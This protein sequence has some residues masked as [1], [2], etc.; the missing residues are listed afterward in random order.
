MACLFSLA[1]LTCYR[2]LVA[3]ATNVS[4]LGCVTCK[5]RRVKCDETRPSCEQCARRRT[6]CDGYKIDVRWK[7][8]RTP[9]QSD[10][11]SSASMSYPL[12][13]TTL[14]KSTHELPGS[15]DHSDAPLGLSASGVA[16]LV[17][18][19]SGIQSPPPN[20]STPPLL[21]SLMQGFGQT[22]SVSPFDDL[23]HSSQTSH[24]QDNHRYS[25]ESPHA[26]GSTDC[27]SALWNLES[28]W[29]EYLMPIAGT[30][31]DSVPLLNDAHMAPDAEKTRDQE[32]ERIAYLF[33]QQTCS[34]LSILDISNQ[35]PLRTLIWPLAQKHP[36]LWYALAAVTCLG[37]SREQPQ[38]RSDGTRY[39]RGST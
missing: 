17:D 5:A 1:S 15:E 18:P 16:D 14:P 30:S 37:M 21:G 24:V 28:F 35:N 34:T 29:E 23:P 22:L 10:R 36:P 32:S 12:S 26:V 19:G 3:I 13:A 31:L 9:T 33:H 8:A 4:S 39:L 6:T 7:Q 2:R 20:L 25:G 38:L 27:T 11:G